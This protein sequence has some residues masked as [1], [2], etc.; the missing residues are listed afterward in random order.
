M[1]IGNNIDVKY[2]IALPL[3]EAQNVIA[4]VRSE[5]ILANLPAL[6]H[7]LWVI[8]G[9]AQGQ[10]LGNPALTA[11]AA[12]DGSTGLSELEKAVAEAKGTVAQ[13]A[14]S[15]VLILKWVIELLVTYYLGK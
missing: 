8:Q 6:A 10:I 11:Y 13:G 3:A 4:I 12:P 15:W 7:D 5:S 1:R 14:I 2:P 9:Y